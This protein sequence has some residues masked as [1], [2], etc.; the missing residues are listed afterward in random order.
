MKIWTILY[1]KYSSS[2]LEDD[3]AG[4]QPSQYNQ[5]LKRGQKLDETVKGSGLGLSIVSELIHDYGGDINLSKSDMGG[6][7][8]TLILPKTEV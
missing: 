3:G 7:R 6:L 5:V 4:I 1:Q 2:G 8:V